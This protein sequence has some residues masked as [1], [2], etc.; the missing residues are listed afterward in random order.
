MLTEQP[1][2][3]KE[4][5]TWPKKFF[6]AIPVWELFKRVVNQITGFA[7]SCLFKDSAI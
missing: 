3:K 2:P 1:W 7:S 5:I 4:F 6:L